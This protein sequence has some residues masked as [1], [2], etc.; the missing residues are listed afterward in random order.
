MCRGQGDG[1]AN[2]AEHLNGAFAHARL[3]PNNL[4]PNGPP[5]VPLSLFHRLFSLWL[6]TSYQGRP[7]ARVRGQ[8][9]TNHRQLPANG[10]TASDSLAPA[11]LVL[12]PSTFSSSQNGW[13]HLPN[14]PLG[15]CK[16][17]AADEIASAGRDCSPGIQSLAPSWS[18]TSHCISF[19]VVF[20]RRQHGRGRAVRYPPS[21][22]ISRALRALFTA[23]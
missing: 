18:T 5:F 6:D 2:S 17:E 9:G 1:S 15:V 4:P 20:L 13:L 12:F 22:T 8:R 14:V 7:I 21:V 11:G 3:L 23:H 16:P 10:Q 19:L